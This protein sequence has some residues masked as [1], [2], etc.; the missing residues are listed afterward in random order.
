[1]NTFIDVARRINR[2]L[3]LKYRV[4]L[5]RHYVSEFGLFG[6]VRMHSALT[7]EQRNGHFR[8]IAIPR[9]KYPVTVRPGTADASTLEKIFVWKQYDLSFP[10]NTR[11]ILDCGANIGLASI[12]FTQACPEARIIA[13]EPELQ[14]YRLLEQNCAPYR[15]IRPLHAAVWNR[16]CDLFLSTPH[17]RV[18]GYQ[19]TES[20]MRTSDAVK[21]YDVSTIMSDHDIDV[22]DVLKIDIEGAEAAVFS[23]NFL[24]WL[25]NTRMLIIEIHSD[26]AR[27]KVEAATALMK[28]Q[29]FTVGENDILVRED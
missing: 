22:I 12:W 11:T 3:G 15:N 16:S 13:I 25:Q 6:A 9:L 2:A 24:G 27:S 23:D 19:F 17:S 10:K 28:W 8:T 14:N 18:D 21:A 29:H 7:T 4:D 1:M 26:E 20:L 5:V